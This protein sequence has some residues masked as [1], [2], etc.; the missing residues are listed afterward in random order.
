MSTPEN[1]ASRRSPPEHPQGVGRIRNATEVATVTP[2][3]R[4]HAGR[5]GVFLVSAWRAVFW[6]FLGVRKGRDLDHDAG[7]FRPV[8]IVVAGLLGALALILALLGL[9]HLVTR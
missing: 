9:V 7:E 3:A 1:A 5:P 2:G 8:Q 6:G 4:K